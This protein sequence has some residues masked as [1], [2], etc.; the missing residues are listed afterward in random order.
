[1]NQPEQFTPREA[2]TMRYEAERA[3]KEM[4]FGMEMKKLDIE[5]QKIE[6]KW[7]VLLKIPIII[8]KLP[9]L[10]LL[11]IGYIIHAIRKIEPSENFWKLLNK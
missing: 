3:D 2:E 10:I 1:M 5:V 11:G 7:S 4:A 6:A 9:L 8:V